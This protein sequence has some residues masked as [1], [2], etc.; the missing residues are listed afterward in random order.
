V[1]RAL[2]GDCLIFPALR[3]NNNDEPDATDIRPIGTIAA[4]RQMA[5]VL[6]GGVHIIVEGLTR[7]KAELATK[8]DVSLRATVAPLA[9]AA[10][11]A[12]RAPLS[13]PASA[14]RERPRSGSRDDRGRS[15]PAHH[16]RLHSGSRRAQPRASAWR[17]RAEDRR[18]RRGE[19]EG[20]GGVT[21][22]AEAAP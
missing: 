14:R 18:D 6:N 13:H 4:I 12:H 22:T 20:S 8:S 2:T 10:E 5:K 11:T 3:N 1:N 16:Q 21:G 17:R 9:E 7:A 15:D 19:R